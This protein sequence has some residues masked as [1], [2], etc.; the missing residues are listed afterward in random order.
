[1]MPVASRMVAR[2]VIAK[3]PIKTSSRVGEALASWHLQDGRH[4][5]VLSLKKPKNSTTFC[6]LRSRP[7][8]P[9]CRMNSVRPEFQTRNGPITS[10][11]ANDESEIPGEKAFGCHCRARP[12]WAGFGNR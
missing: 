6:R 10:I 8:H 11:A 3:T 9:G 12:P 2:K 7:G 4:Y 1:M 5:N